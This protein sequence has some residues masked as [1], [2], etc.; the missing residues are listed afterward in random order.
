MAPSSSA[1]EL[2]AYVRSR[3]ESVV[4]PGLGMDLEVLVSQL[5]SQSD[6]ASLKE[7]ARAV[8]GLG[9]GP[10]TPASRRLERCID[11]IA[12]KVFSSPKKEGK[13]VVNCLVCGYCNV[14]IGQT[15]QKRTYE[16]HM[17]AIQKVRQ[18]WPKCAICAD[19]LR[20][21]LR[22]G[23]VDNEDSKK[24]TELA[25]RLFRYDRDSKKKQQVVDDQNDW[26]NN[27]SSDDQ[28][29]EAKQF[30]QERTF[31]IDFA[32]RKVN[33]RQDDEEDEVSP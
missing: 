9:N 15:P 33:I 29:Q 16:G 19:S 11:D 17:A 1:Q 26:Y 3:L 10:Q 14:V 30:K 28:Q 25:A 31:T 4:D 13:L 24:A 8:F 22:H 18:Q 27:F 2:Q 23:D 7:E 20:E 21:Q 5:L 6:A 32:G 12:T